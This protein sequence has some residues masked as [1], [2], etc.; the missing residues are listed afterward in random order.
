MAPSE[1]KAPMNL[2][3]H[4]LFGW[5]EVERHARVRNGVEI[6]VVKV[7]KYLRI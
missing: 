2:S 7:E 6:P 5:R 4:S 3:F 1:R